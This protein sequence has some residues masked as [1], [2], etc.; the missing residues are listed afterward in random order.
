M[1]GET[2]TPNIGLQ[3][4]GFGQANWQVPNNYNFNLLDLIM[5]GEVQIPNLSVANLEVT[6]FTLA[7]F[8]ALLVGSLTTEVPAGTA[9]TTTYVLSSPAAA[10]LGLFYNGVL[11]SPMTDYTLSG[12]TVT[13]NFTTTVGSTIYAVYF[14]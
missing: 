12:N 6:S 3:I 7:N 13:L 14:K 5:G 4:A 8:A 9:P 1:A 11:Q 2:S 10:M